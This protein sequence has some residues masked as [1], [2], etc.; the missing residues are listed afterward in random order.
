V[1]SVVPFRIPKC[2]LVDLYERK[3]S[4]ILRLPRVSSSPAA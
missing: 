2:C 1:R 3:L 4:K